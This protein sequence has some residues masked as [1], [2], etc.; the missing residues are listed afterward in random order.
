MLATDWKQ[1]KQIYILGIG[2]IGVSAVARLLVSLGQAVSGSNDNESEVTKNLVEEGIKVDLGQRLDFIPAGTDL[3]IYSNA[4]KIASPE[5]FAAVK[6]LNITTLSYPEMLGLISADYYTIA[7]AGTHGKTT[8]T[9]M[10]AKVLTEAGLDPTVIVGTLLLDTPTGRRTNFVAG[11]SRYLVV[12]ADEY[13]RAFLNLQPSLLVITNIDLDHLDYYHDLADIQSAFAELVGRVAAEG[14]II[15]NTTQANLTPVLPAAKAKIIDYSSL[16]VETSKLALQVPGQHNIENAKA[17]LAV[18]EVLGIRDQGAVEA[19][20]KFSGT[21]RR[22]EFKGQTASG[23]LVY[24]D[25]AHNP[26]KVRAALQGAREAFPDK[27]IIAVFQPHLYSRTKALFND[28]V[29]AF[30]DADEVLITPIYAA[31]EKADPTVSSESLTQAISQTGKSARY[32][33]SLAEASS[34]LKQSVGPKDLILLLG[35]GDISLVG[36]SLL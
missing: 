25:Y 31:R 2:G 10:I 20:N 36:I 21:W 5:F 19:L 13:Q 17:A 26:A 35:A 18:A 28:F 12:E 8:T 32:C 34:Y 22:F 33:E 23:A 24:D 14:T 30:A 11:S 16:G 7:I 1:A 29:T 6:A 3:I 15:A 9:A 27:K 4:I